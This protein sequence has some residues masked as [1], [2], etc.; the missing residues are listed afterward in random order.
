[1]GDIG[2]YGF[3]WFIYGIH[4]GSVKLLWGYIVFT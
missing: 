3:W 4:W 2:V 1:M